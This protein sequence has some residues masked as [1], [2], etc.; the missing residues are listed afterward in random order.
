MDSA[1]VYHQENIG[2][3]ASGSREERRRS[4]LGV[5]PS[6]TDVVNDQ[7]ER[8][9]A[10]TNSSIGAEANN[11]VQKRLQ[12]LRHPSSS[13]RPPTNN[14]INPPTAVTA[15]SSINRA[16][17]DPIGASLNPSGSQHARNFDQMQGLREQ[18]QQLKSKMAQLNLALD[19]VMREN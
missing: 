13:R 3:G 1:G 7:A 17:N 11:F 8:I 12:K 19:S 10:Y 2:N 15:N 4:S 16:S 9:Q 18:N 14:S 5:A 6:Q